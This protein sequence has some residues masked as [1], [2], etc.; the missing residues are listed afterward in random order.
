VTD[1]RTLDP[2]LDVV[3]KL[4]FAAEKNRPLLAS[5]LNAVLEP[6]EPIVEL[7]VLNPEVTRESVAQHGAILDVRVR[8]RDGRQADVEMQAAPCAALRERF[9]Y[10]WARAFSEQLPRGSGHARLMPVIGVFILGFRELPGSRLHSVYALR[11]AERRDVLSEALEL[12]FL[13][14]PKI[15]AEVDRPDGPGGAAAALVNWCRFLAAQSDEELE[16][17]AMV[18]PDL[19]AAKKALDE[20][21]ADP[22][23]RRLAEERRLAEWNYAYTLYAE[24]AEGRAEGLS[25]GLAKG[26]TGLLLRMLEARFGPVPAE[27]EAQIRSAS[28]AD[29]AGY[30]D[31]LLTAATLR[32][33]LKA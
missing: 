32:D 33:V 8:L 10:Y 4:L 17:L 7:R 22:E 19:S 16:I 30:A 20:L 11:E 21:S 18:N 13:E 12:H 14:L 25:E 31:R 2:K 29:I 26:Q 24:R 23:A 3:F 28:A 9:L 15:A 27:V 5:L 1:R 6:S